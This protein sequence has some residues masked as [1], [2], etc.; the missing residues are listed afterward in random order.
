MKI[1]L[2][3]SNWKTEADFI[4]GVLAGVQAP[5]WHD[6]NYNALRDS[7]VVA[8]SSLLTILS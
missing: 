4:E 8:G 1:A 7:L 2:N 3:G 6:R 5:S